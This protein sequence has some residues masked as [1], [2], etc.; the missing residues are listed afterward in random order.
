MKTRFNGK[1]GKVIYFDI[2]EVSFNYPK[3]TLKLEVHI[4]PI[5]GSKY[6]SFIYTNEPMSVIEEKL[7]KIADSLLMYKKNSYGS[8]EISDA[9]SSEINPIFSLK[10][11]IMYLNNQV[12]KI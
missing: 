8:K 3:G 4:Y 11:G 10:S 9:L 6:S 7:Q 5:E 12:F 2:E 1:D